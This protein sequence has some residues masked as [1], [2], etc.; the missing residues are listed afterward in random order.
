M[1]GSEAGACPGPRREGTTCVAVPAPGPRAR[2]FRG[3]LPPPAFRTGAAG[4]A[5]VR[6]ELGRFVARLCHHR[7]RPRVTSSSQPSTPLP[8][9]TCSLTSP[10]RRA[11][12]I[13]GHRAVWKHPTS[14]SCEAGLGGS[15][16]SSRLLPVSYSRI[17]GVLQPV[18]PR[19]GC[20]GRSVVRSDP[21]RKQPG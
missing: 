17:T 12:P 13:S 2:V 21:P 5:P 18:S 3:V 1:V 19:A 8:A 20:A 10:F 4:E 7:A 16:W 9:L 14:T 15:R 6:P 11:A